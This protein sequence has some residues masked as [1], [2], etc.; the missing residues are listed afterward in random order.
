MVVSGYLYTLA[1]KELYRIR[2]AMAQL[3]VKGGFFEPPSASVIM[4]ILKKNCE[5]VIYIKICLLR[6]E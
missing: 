5:I 6:R 1:M 3:V 2:S 4:V